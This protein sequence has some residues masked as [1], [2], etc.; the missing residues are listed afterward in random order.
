MNP[1][2]VFKVEEIDKISKADGVLQ[3]RVY[4]KDE[5]N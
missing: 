2:K 4:T 3:D 1:F 5:W